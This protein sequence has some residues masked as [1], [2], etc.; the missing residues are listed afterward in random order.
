MTAPALPFRTAGEITA[1][2]MDGALRQAGVLA[3]GAAVAEVQVSPV[4]TGQMADS[5]RVALTYDGT[6]RGAPSVREPST[7]A[8]RLPAGHRLDGLHQHHLARHA[9]LSFAGGGPTDTDEAGEP[10]LFMAHG[11]LDVNA[12]YAFA[13][14]DH[15]GLFAHADELE[16]LAA[17]WLYEVLD[18][19]EAQDPPLPPTTGPPPTV[20]TVDTVDTVPNTPGPP[21]T[22]GEPTGGPATTSPP[23]PP[24]PAPPPAAPRSGSSNYAG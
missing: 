20:D 21:V 15:F 1:R 8:R 7:R 5:L 11:E 18:L 2:A 17:V 16:T 23:M 12:P 6:V 9:V 13:G 22:S 14:A 4:G 19:A 10:P 3:D 24:S